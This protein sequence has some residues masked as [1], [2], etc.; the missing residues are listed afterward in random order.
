[1]KI[2]INILI[3]SLLCV[4]T[5]NAEDYIISSAALNQKLYEFEKRILQLEG[6]ENID[7][8]TIVYDGGTGEISVGIIDGDNI[9]VTSLSAISADLGTITAGL[10][11]GATIQTATGNPKVVMDSDGLT[12]ADGSGDYVLQVETTGANVGDV[13]L[14]DY[15]N[16][17]GAKW[18][19]SEMAFTIKGVIE[20]S[21]GSIGGFTI[22]ATSLTGGSGATGV[23]LAPGSYPFYA[24]SETP[25]VAPF[26][27]S[28]AGAVT[29]SSGTIGGWTL[30][31]DKISSA[32]IEIDSSNER[33]RTTDYVSGA[34]G[35]GW[36]IDNTVAEFNNIRARGKISTSVFE[37]NAISTVGGSFAVLDGDILGSDMTA[38][39]ASTMTISGDTTF[40]VGDILR[41]KDGI[42]DEWFEVTNAGSAPS[43]T[44]TRDKASQYSANS[45]PIWKKGTAVVNFG[46]SGDGGVFMT[47][48]E[49][50][51]PYIHFFTQ[52]GTPWTS[53]EG[54]VRIGNLDGIP[55]ASGYGIWGGAGFLGELSVID[56]IS[57][58]SQGEIRS[59]TSGNYPYLSFSNAG[60]Q[61]KDSDTG[62]TYGTAVYGTDKYG[63]GAL[64]W[65]GNADM[66]VPIII[67]KEPS[68]G[69]SDV[70]DMRF[71][72]RSDNPGGAAEIGDIVVVSGELKICTGAGTPGTWQKVGSQ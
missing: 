15:D 11:T 12:A 24:G 4:S 65:I 61:L 20:A 36:Q 71:Y 58:S 38:A 23:G 1:M 21:S 32:N 49:P 50:Y 22:G 27:V 30:S 31:S 37:K 47:A 40:S 57:I 39:D 8:A 6:G 16:S 26:R 66:E 51:S 45:N 46:Q 41:M 63:Y 7:D 69:A 13:T 56:T 55:G 18:D 14:G 28:N 5:V 64:A 62:G 9:S 3:I 70:A 42:D 10:L 44:V 17:H 67:L 53:L 59:N 25:N 35:S 43:Y 72:N 34:L 54:K 29:A 2:F 60:L 52:D 68:A 48:S 19:Q 33:I